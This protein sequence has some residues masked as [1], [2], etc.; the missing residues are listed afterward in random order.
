MP[1]RAA[2]ASNANHYAFT[3]SQQFKKLATAVQAPD[4]SHIIPYLVQVPNNLSVFLRRGRHPIFDTRILTLVQVPNNS[5][6]SLRLCR[7]RQC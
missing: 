4:A 1:V 3:R 5:S 7:F 6:N 2:D